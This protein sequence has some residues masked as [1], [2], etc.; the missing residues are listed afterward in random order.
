MQSSPDAKPHMKQAAELEERFDPVLY[1]VAD[2]DNR[3]KV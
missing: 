3:A 2:V 1:T